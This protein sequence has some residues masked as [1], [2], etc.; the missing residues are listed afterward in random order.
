MKSIGIEP[1]R[2]AASVLFTAR[3]AT[4]TISSFMEE[5]R[6]PYVISTMI[7]ARYLIISARGVSTDESAARRSHV[8][9]QVLDKV[10][11]GLRQV[12]QQLLDLPELDV[13]VAA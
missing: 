1:G 11:R 12:A 9:M 10:L 3:S 8:Q 4:R 2:P 7:A 5:T 13:L 6:R